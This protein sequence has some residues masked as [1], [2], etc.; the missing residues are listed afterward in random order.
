MEERANKTENHIMRLLK[1]LSE[2]GEYAGNQHFLLFLQC[3]PQPSKTK[4]INS[5]TL[6]LYQMTNF[7]TVQLQNILRIN[8]NL[9]KDFSEI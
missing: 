9:E 1:T 5:A 4:D 6:T 7:K 8:V 2:M 3:S